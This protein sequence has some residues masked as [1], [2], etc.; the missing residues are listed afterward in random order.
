MQRISSYSKK[1]Q[2]LEIEIKKAKNEVRDKQSHMCQSCHRPNDEI[3]HNYPVKHFLW[4]AAEKE[5]MVLLCRSHHRSFEDNRLFELDQSLVKR[6]IGDMYEM[7][8]EEI[9]LV[10]RDMML[11]HVKNKL[12]KLS[13]FPEG[14]ELADELFKLIE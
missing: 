12:F 10:R 3:S 14:Q 7:A 2:Q 5:N 4:L 6:I 8:L 1:R 9:D 13:D 11:S